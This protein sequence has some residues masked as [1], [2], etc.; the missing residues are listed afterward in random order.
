MGIALRQWIGMWLAT[1]LA[2]ISWPALQVQAQTTHSLA[3]PG[4]FV[5]G[6]LEVTVPR[7]SGG[8]FAATVVYPATANGLGTPV[9]AAAGPHPAIAF[10]HGFQQ[11]VAAYSSTLRHLATWGFI[12]IA[13]RSYESSLLPNHSQFAN[14]L[15]DSLNFLAAQS[16]VGTSLFF[17]AVNVNRFGV[18]GHSMGG[19]A[20]LIAAD[21]EPRILAI[22]NMAAAE[23][24][25]SAIRAM[26]G[27]TRPVQLI[28]GSSDGI[29]PPDSN[30]V[31]MYNAGNAPRQAPTILGGSH[32][33]FQDY[34]VFSLFC[35]TGLIPKA[36]QLRITRRLLTAWFLLYLR[37]DTDLWQ[38]V[39]GPSARVQS[40]PQFTGDDGMVL[41]PSQAAIATETGQAW[42]IT[43]SVTNTQ[44]LSN[45]YA[46]A[47]TPAISSLVPYSITPA[48]HPSGTTSI[49]LTVTGTVAGQYALTMTVR[50][51]FDGGTTDWANI[52]ATITSSMIITP[53]QAV[54][55]HLP[56]IQKHTP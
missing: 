16:A 38:A 39:W 42:V 9:D 28:A 41:M 48:I 56:V 1:A 54:T 55:T 19:G 35:D 40:Q 30:Q 36:D 44:P 4:P 10:G 47:V 7:S 5:A 12:V 37:G 34:A 11:P 2:V 21:R 45:S 8:S 27:I 50:S 6:W 25:P 18:S 15:I 22:S 52:T 24:M 13:P 43:F 20:S 29:V 26:T 46:I 49:P 17:Q 32:C 14:D 23:T 31:P 51:M 33:N 53:S 3:D